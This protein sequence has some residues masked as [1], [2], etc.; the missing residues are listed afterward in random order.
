MIELNGTWFYKAPG[1]KVVDLMEAFFNKPI[2]SAKDLTL[3][4]FA[5]PATGEN[6]LSAEDGINNVYTTMNALPK[7]RIEYEP[8]EIKAT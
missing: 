5:P 1:T 3:K 8:V 2:K 4:F 7:I 6:D